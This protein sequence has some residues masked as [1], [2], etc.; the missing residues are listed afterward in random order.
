[1]YGEDKKT[2]DT[3]SIKNRAIRSLTGEGL[4]SKATDA[5]SA[6]DAKATKARLRPASIL[7]NDH[8]SISSYAELD[9]NKLKAE[10]QAKVDALKKL[11]QEGGIQSYLAS[12]P[13][14]QLVQKMSEEVGFVREFVGPDAASE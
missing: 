6:E 3:D 7:N 10:R 5:A 2:G 11:I 9:P 13:T 1:M 8:V 12:V 4:T 14:T